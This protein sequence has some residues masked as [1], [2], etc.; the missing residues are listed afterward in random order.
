MITMIMNNDDGGDGDDAC[1]YV[2]I[3]DRRKLFLRKSREFNNC[4]VS[5]NYFKIIPI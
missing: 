4:L 1:V 2:H 5:K 3:R